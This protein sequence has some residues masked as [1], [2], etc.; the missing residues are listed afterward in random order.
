M[1]A[2]SLSSPV[3][4]PPLLFSPRKRA[5]EPIAP[6][7]TC[8][9]S[10]RALSSVVSTIGSPSSLTAPRLVTSPRLASPCSDPAPTLGVCV[11][12]HARP[13]DLLCAL[14][15]LADTLPPFLGL[16]ALPD[17]HVTA[18]GTFDTLEQDGVSNQP[19]TV[20]FRAT[21]RPKAAGNEEVS[22]SGLCPS[23]CCFFF[24]FVVLWHMLRREAGP[25]APVNVARCVCRETPLSPGSPFLTLSYRF[26]LKQAGAASAK[27]WP[28]LQAI[29]SFCVAVATKVSPTRRLQTCRLLSSQDP[30]WR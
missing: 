23:R 28:T 30:R 11:G 3:P 19:A 15:L 2:A 17:R 21:L 8:A 10:L 20:T 16:A 13:P 26:C 14:P 1:A 5:G 18:V 24:D 29:A 9:T 25:A 12:N 22:G 4:P 6:N 27:P 7:A